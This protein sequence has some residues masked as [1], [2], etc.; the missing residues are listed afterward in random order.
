MGTDLLCF[1]RALGLISLMFA[2]YVLVAGRPK[3]YVIQE[4]FTALLEVNLDNITVVKEKYF[5]VFLI[6]TL[7]GKVSARKT[8]RETWANFTAWAAFTTAEQE[9]LNFKLMFI[10]GNTRNKP[11]SAEFIEES[12]KHKDIVIASALDEHRTVLK[13][14][15][16]WGLQRIQRLYDYKFIIKTD[17]D[18]LVNLPLVLKKLQ[19]LQYNSM[20]YGGDCYQRYGGYSGLPRYWYCSG[21][22]YFLSSDMVTSFKGLGE[23]VQNVPFRPEDGYIG[24]LVYN[25]NKN[26]NFSLKVP[27]RFPHVLSLYGYKCG[28][29]KHWFYHRIGGTTA[30]RSL[31][32]RIQSNLTTECRS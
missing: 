20:V 24:W 9:Y 2:L 23:E 8:V 31:F 27:K 6:P 5:A 4:E 17:D 10:V 22:G 16:L 30:I 19:S 32:E 1:V 26:L 15:V 28:T 25:V 3:K 12:L 14:K 18:I 7:P 13:Y 21:G 11:Y 29:F